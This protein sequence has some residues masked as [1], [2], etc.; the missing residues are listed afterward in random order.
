MPLI[1]RRLERTD[2]R[3]Q[4]DCGDGPLNDYIRRYA[5]QNQ[6][7]HL[8]GVT[9]VGVESDHPQTVIGYYTLAAS[10]IPTESLPRDAVSHLPPYMV[11]PVVLLARL[12][13]HSEFK[14]RKV[15][16]ALLGDALG[17]CADIGLHIGCRYVIVDAYQTAVDWYSE[18]GFIPLGGAAPGAKTQKMFIDLRT[19]EHGRKTQ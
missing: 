3:E 15:G 10:S 14:G 13:V 17:R 9:Y 5:W 18:Y 8:V 12:A 6:E 11:V 4:F 16:P 2:R 7:A 1:I 19:V